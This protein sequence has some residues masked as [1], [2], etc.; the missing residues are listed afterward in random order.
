V[1]AESYVAGNIRVDQ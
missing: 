1:Q